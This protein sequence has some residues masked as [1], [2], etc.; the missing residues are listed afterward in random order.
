MVSGLKHVIS[1]K[2]HLIEYYDIF[3]LSPTMRQ[4]NV[5]FATFSIDLHNWLLFCWH[6]E[7]K[8][9]FQ[10]FVFILFQSFLLTYSDILSYDSNTIYSIMTNSFVDSK[11]K[12]FMFLI[13]VIDF[14][15]VHLQIYFE[16]D[17]TICKLRF[18]YDPIYTTLIISLFYC[19]IRQ[20]NKELTVRN[21]WYSL[22]SV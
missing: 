13:C 6:Y 18:P 9:E 15:K 1:G 3:N 22:R 14:E 19:L 7:Y 21:L 12:S 11:W 10:G 20:Y 16:L 8:K 5:L 2:D 17:E 4:P